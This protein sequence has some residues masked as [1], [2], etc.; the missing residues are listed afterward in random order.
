[1][2]TLLISYDLNKP[3]QNY[4]TL[5]EDQG[6]R[7]VVALPRLDLVRRVLADPQQG[8]R[9]AKAQPGQLRQRAH[10]A[11]H[12]RQLLRLA[13]TR[14]LGLAEKARLATGLQN[15]VRAR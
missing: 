12:R 9:P 5:Y 8:I 14:S 11:H 13:S 6:A 7:H 10:H 15:L 2:G 1:M 4:D 3:G